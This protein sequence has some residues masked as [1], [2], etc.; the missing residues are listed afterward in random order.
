MKQK[1]ALDCFKSKAE[2]IGNVSSLEELYDVLFS[3]NSTFGIEYSTG[4]KKTRLKGKD[5][6][7]WLRNE[8]SGK[9]SGCDIKQAKEGI[10]KAMDMPVGRKDDGIKALCLAPSESALGMYSLLALCA[11]GATVV[12]PQDDRL[13]SVSETARN[14]DVTH[15][16]AYP[17]MLSALMKRAQKKAAK[18]R[19]LES[20]NKALSSS[21]PLGKLIYGLILKETRT[22]MLGSSAEVI[23]TDNNGLKSSITSFFFKLSYVLGYF[24]SDSNM[25]VDLM[26]EA[27]DSM[28][29]RSNA[30]IKD[31]S[32]KDVLVVSVDPALSPRRTSSVIRQVEAALKDRSVSA[33]FTS[34]DLSSGS[35]MI[36]RSRVAEEYNSGAIKLIDPSGLP[37]RSVM[38]EAEVREKVT[39]CFARV[40]DRSADEISFTGDFFKSFNGES[41]DYFV[42]LGD[43]ENVFDIEL[44]SKEGSRLSSVKDFTRYILKHMDD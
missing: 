18:N 20:L 43:L 38:S 3:E 13:Q 6:E 37:A 5:A 32:G 1:K 9:L 4:L 10:L 22:E 11:I 19:R 36:D 34:D 42:L 33:A 14:H 21:G 12:L 25:P 15:V 7:S 26:E 17:L 24:N 27:V 23:F 40:L 29:I 41:L 39:V 31:S 30:L 44:S 16:I 2:L 28:Y 8:M 35:Y